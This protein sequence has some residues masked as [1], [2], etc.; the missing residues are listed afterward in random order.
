[1]QNHKSDIQCIKLYFI[2]QHHTHIS[3]Q[4]FAYPAKSV[5]MATV[6]KGHL[7]KII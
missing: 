3:N 4:L 7:A 1:M 2:V 5:L 6:N